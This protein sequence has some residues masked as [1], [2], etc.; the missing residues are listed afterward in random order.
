MY[1]YIG[2]LLS[3]TCIIILSA[4]S[5]RAVSMA[6]YSPDIAIYENE[7]VENKIIDNESSFFPI[8]EDA[9]ARIADIIRSDFDYEIQISAAILDIH[10]NELVASYGDIDKQR[11]AVYAFWPI[12]AAILIEEI[13]LSIHDE[14]ENTEIIF[15]F[16]PW[17]WEQ[18]GRDYYQGSISLTQG[19]F[20]ANHSIFHHVLDGQG[21][22]GMIDTW[23]DFN[24]YIARGDLKVSPRELL[25]LY[26]SL[27][28]GGR[29]FSDIG[30]EEYQQIFGEQA[31]T[32][33][34]EVLSGL[35]NAIDSNWDVFRGVRDR[36]FIDDFKFN[37]IGSLS[38]YEE[39]DGDFTGAWFIGLYPA[40]APAYAVVINLH[41]ETRYF[42]WENTRKAG[43]LDLAVFA[44]ELFEH[45]RQNSTNDAFIEGIPT[46]FL[47][48]I[49][50]IKSLAS[51]Y[52]TGL[53]YVGRDTCPA[54]LIFNVRLKNLYL[55]FN[56]L[57]IYFFDT[58][59]WREHE[60]FETVLN[61]YGIATVPTLL[62]INEYGEFAILLPNNATMDED[63]YILK[64]FLGLPYS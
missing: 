32:E 9:I 13:G 49:T 18:Q 53:L 4:C 44:Y 42:D 45:T 3:L 22:D 1:K 11:R 62:N 54:C 41:Y 5:G 14:F 19:I 38:E 17:L 59:Y 48:L 37:L 43:M 16:L 28:N 30:V 27:I 8:E 58:D 35:L 26:A 39:D 6:Y 56:E 40:E 7:S 25:L 10:N 31:K 2:V 55:N 47:P 50:D 33:A 20:D 57:S 61:K 15:S 29:L 36:S 12:S 46:D 23:G 51:G 63:M 34:T 64:S 24:S 21:L 52:Y 60:L